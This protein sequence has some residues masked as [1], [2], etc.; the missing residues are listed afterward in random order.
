MVQPQ[1]SDVLSGEGASEFTEQSSSPATRLATRI[2]KERA[3]W[4]CGAIALVTAIFAPIANTSW[5]FIAA[6]LPAYQTTII[7]AYTITAYLTFAHYRV[8]RAPAL[9]Y[10]SGGCIYTGTILIAQFASFSGM[11]LPGK[12]LIGGP[13]TTI[14]LWFFWHLGPPAGVLFSIARECLPAGSLRILS[15][16]LGLFGLSLIVLTGGSIAAVTLFRDFLLVLDVQGDYSRITETGLAPALQVI[17]A[18]ALILLWRT[19]KFRT[20]LQIWLGVGL[21]ALLCDNTITMLGEHRLSVGW[22][23]GRVNGLISAAVILFVYLAEINGAYF[24]SM[25]N[26]KELAVAHTRLKTKVAQARIDQLTGL[27]GRA[28]FLEQAQMLM[29]RNTGNRTASAVL[30]VDLDGFKRVN[31]QYGHG[32]GDLVLAQTASIL[33]ASLRDGDVAGRVGGDE[34]VVCI[35]APSDILEQTAKRVAGRIVGK[36][37]EIGSGIGCSVGIALPK[38]SDTDLNSTIKNADEAMYLAKKRGKNRFVVHGRPGLV[39]VA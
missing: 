38:S 17:S 29:A 26:A 33:R 28:M 9:L 24:K 8:T 36:V 4:T 37:S 11:F 1:S 10:L 12:P 20:V 16:H 5:P 30:Y 18:S 6:F 3:L 23:I 27:P 21:V 34:F 22:Y 2:Q 14:W 15:K 31:D 25:N 19:T 39:A 35:A 32:Q 13:Q 7:L